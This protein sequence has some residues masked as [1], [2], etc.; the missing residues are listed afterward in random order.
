M[1]HAGD[2]AEMQ[3]FITEYFGPYPLFVAVRFGDWADGA[4]NRRSPTRACRFRTR[5]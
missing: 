2:I 4:C 1:M 5:L 3:A